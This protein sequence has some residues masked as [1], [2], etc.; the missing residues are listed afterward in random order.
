[1]HC[2]RL[3]NIENKVAA[4]ICAFFTCIAHFAFAGPCT[5][6]LR[7][8]MEKRFGT[9]SENPCVDRSDFDRASFYE[10]FVHEIIRFFVSHLAQ[11]RQ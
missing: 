2:V 11:A 4:A 6:Q 7:A 3:H 5:V 9:G 1:M 8:I 10:H